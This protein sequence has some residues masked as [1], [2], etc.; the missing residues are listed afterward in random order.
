MCSKTRDNL[1]LKA[2]ISI[3]RN[4]ACPLLAQWETNKKK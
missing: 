3:L 4:Y 1:K 2:L